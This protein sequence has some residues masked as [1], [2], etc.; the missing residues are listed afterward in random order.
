MGKEIERKFLVRDRQFETEATEKFEIRQAYLNDCP[1]A[2]VRLRVIDTKAWLTVKSRNHGAERGEWEYEIPVSDA[3]EMIE[4][5][6]TPCLFKTRYIIP[7][8]D[9]L[10]WEV[11][12]FHNPCAGLVVAEIELPSS[13]TAITHPAWIGREITGDPAYYNSVI[14]A[15]LKT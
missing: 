6:D 11:D 1:D 9:G 5:T 7:A 3:M 4:A 8:A 15:K 10:K 2:T 12:E 14:A 13:D